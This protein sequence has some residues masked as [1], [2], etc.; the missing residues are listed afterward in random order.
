MYSAVDTKQAFASKLKVLCA[1]G[2][3]SGLVPSN[4]SKYMLNRTVK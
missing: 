4:Y 3:G 2:I 1:L